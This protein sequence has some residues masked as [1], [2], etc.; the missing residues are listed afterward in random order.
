MDPDEGSAAM[1]TI[2]IFDKIGRIME[3]DEGTEAVKPCNH[4]K[5]GDRLAPCSVLADGTEKACAKCKRYR[6]SCFSESH[7]AKAP[8]IEERF[9]E[10][11]GQLEDTKDEFERQLDDTKEQL[12]EMKQQLG[13]AL[14]RQSEDTKKRLGEMKQ[15]FGVALKRQMVDTKK[16]LGE[17]KQ[18]LGVANE[19]LGEMKQQLDVANERIATLEG[20]QDAECVSDS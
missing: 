20:E 9:T 7:P 2:R 12:G 15:Q 3:T 6:K 5:R 8:T 18:Q 10:L 1:T 19:R 4:C 11:E 17:M 14:K 13:V 16:Q